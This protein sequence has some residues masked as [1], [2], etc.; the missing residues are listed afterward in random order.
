[1][2]IG[3]SA[4]F[5]CTALNLSEDIG[6]ISFHL[7]IDELLSGEEF[8]VYVPDDPVAKFLSKLVSNQIVRP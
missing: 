8:S 5:G 4:I 1:M 2:N 3:C 7:A 6:F